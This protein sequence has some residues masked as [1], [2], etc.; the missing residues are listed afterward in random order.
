MQM[1]K[2]F[3]LASG[4][5]IYVEVEEADI[6]IYQEE[7]ANISDLPP[8][9]EPTGL[10]DDVIIGGQLLQESIRGVA[11]SVRDS[12]KDMKPD[13][14]SVEINIGMKGKATIIPVLVS[15]EGNG[16]IKV[17]AKWKRDTGNAE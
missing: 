13:E 2:A 14:W 4:E 10:V 3:K 15:G 9:A 7:T 1:V 16:S 12:L 5:T 17:I 6:Q 8:G 11:Q